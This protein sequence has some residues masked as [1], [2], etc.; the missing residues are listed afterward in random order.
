LTTA[1]L[2]KNTDLFF[3]GDF[4]IS[5]VESEGENQKKTCGLDKQ[6]RFI[7]FVKKYNPV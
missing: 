1:I 6:V 5:Y 7:N 4:D 3:F 2:K